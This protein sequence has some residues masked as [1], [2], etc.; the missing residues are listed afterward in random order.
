MALDYEKI[1]GSN[2]ATQYTFSD[3]DYLKG[4]EFIGATPPARQQFD[5]WMRNADK[6]MLETHND[7]VKAGNN[8]AAHNADAAAH[9]PILDAIKA[10]TGLDFGT[11]PSR[12]ITNMITLLGQGGIVA[13]RLSETGF[14]KFAN[15]FTIQWGTT[16]KPSNNGVKATLAIAVTELFAVVCTGIVDSNE[17]NYKLSGSWIWD[18][19]TTTELWFRTNVV[20]APALKYMAIGKT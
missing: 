19:S 4:W 1:W 13:A 5:A 18:L 11:A 7:I 9:K 2:A 15:G 6:K 12:T 10:I 20:D 16:V 14:V 17:P 8:L 3:I